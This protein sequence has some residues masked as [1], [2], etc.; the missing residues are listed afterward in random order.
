MKHIN[1]KFVWLILSL[2]IFSL[3]VK[4]QQEKFDATV[5]SENGRKAYQTLLKIELFAIG[6]IEYSGETSDGEKA[7]D[8][9]IEEKEAESAFKNLAKNGTLEGGL[10]GLLGLKMLDCNCFQNELDEY[11]KE[12]ISKDTKEKFSMMAGCELIEAEKISDKQS[13]IVDY[14]IS[15]SF[16]VL[17]SHKKLIR[18]RRKN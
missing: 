9:L 6:G 16:D 2:I 4:A 8:I 12:K 1:R 5:L 3:Q 15:E 11:K 7:F 18:E 17:V 14:L 10:Y 13:V